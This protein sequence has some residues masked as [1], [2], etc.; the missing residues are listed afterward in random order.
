MSDSNALQWPGDLL[1]SHTGLLVF[2]FLSDWGGL[3]R[4]RV[5]PLAH[6]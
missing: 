2:W 3:V 1:G 6:S 4:G 5:S